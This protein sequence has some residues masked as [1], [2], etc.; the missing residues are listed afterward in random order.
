MSSLTIAGIVFAC[1]F[2][3]ALLGMLLRAV[4]PDR[5]LSAE[6]KDVMKLGMGLIATMSALVLGLLV[7]SAKGS[8]D[9]QKN[10]LAQLSGN[11]VFLDRLL[12]HYGPEAREARE[13]LRAAAA[14]MLA[15]TW[16]EEGSYS[17]SEGLYEGPFE[18][19]QGL[20]PKNEAQRTLQAQALKVGAD[21]AQSRW[22]L[23]A[24]RGSS[25]PT[26]FLVVMVS[27]LAILFVSFSL[28]ARLNAT[29]FATLLLSA[30]TVSSAIFLILE[31][32]RPYE[33]IIQISSAPLR[34][35]L[36]QLGR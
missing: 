33:G 26:P 35:A 19:I 2:G 11:L 25:I 23:F 27:W 3:G 28:H 20:S 18:Q 32:D 34:N 21:I 6:T 15:R 8:F 12:A 5:H 4:L 7:A 16:P 13:Q 17:G 1:I 14:D 24:Q 29:V 36:G 10:G 9:A 22:S 31:L 30:L